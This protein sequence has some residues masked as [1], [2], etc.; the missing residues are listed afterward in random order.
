MSLVNVSS[1]TVI[2]Y[3]FKGINDFVPIVGT[4]SWYLQLAPTVGTHSLYLQL[5]PIVGTYSLYL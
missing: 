1:V 2:L 4:Y 5:V 3:L